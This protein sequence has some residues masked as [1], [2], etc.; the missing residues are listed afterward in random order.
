MK[1]PFFLIISCRLVLGSTPG[2]RDALEEN[3]S[4]VN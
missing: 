1:N 4:L 2:E 3:E